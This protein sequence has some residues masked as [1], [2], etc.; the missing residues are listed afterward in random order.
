MGVS[1]FFS[2][3]FALYGIFF[4]K[5]VE[6]RNMIDWVYKKFILFRNILGIDLEEDYGKI[7]A[8]VVFGNENIF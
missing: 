3:S 7:K 8:K 6:I 4:L 1:L 5:K 2:T